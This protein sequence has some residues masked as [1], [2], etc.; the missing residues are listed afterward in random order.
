MYIQNNIGWLAGSLDNVLKMTLVDTNF[1]LTSFTCLNR[2]ADRPGHSLHGVWFE[3]TH[4]DGRAWA[5]K[6]MHNENGSWLS[7]YD[8]KTKKGGYNRATDAN[9][10]AFDKMVDRVLDKA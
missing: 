6:L 1:K 2:G 4:T 8:Y 5:L 3:L 10:V 9:S 7:F